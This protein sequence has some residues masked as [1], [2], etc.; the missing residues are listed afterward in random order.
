LDR[1]GNDR[2]RYQPRLDPRDR[3]HRHRLP[4]QRAGRG[5]GTGDRPSAGHARGHG[6]L[7]PPPAR[8]VRPVAPGAGGGRGH[9]RGRGAHAGLPAGVGARELFADVRQLDLPGPAFPAPADAGAGAP[10]PLPQPG[11]EHAQ[12]TGA[13]LGPAGPGRRTQGGRP[14]RPE[15]R[16]RLHRRTPPLP[17]AHGRTRR[18]LA[19]HPPALDLARASQVS[20]T[21]SGLRDTD[22]IPCSISHWARSGWSLGPCPQMPTYL[23]LARAVAMAMDSIFFTA[24]S[25]SSNSPATIA[26]S[27]SRPTVS[28]VM[29]LE[30]IEKPSKISRNSSA[31]RAFEGISHIMMI[32]S[33]P[34]PWTSPFSRS[35]STT[36]RPS[37][38]V[39]TNGIITQRLSRPISSRTRLTA[40]H[41]SAKQSLNDGS[42]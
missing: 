11:R 21:V 31:S 30:P 9:G 22:S 23:P 18:L 38:R 15:R 19:S 33:P 6:R 25:R 42:T 39:R 3:H 17:Q 37:S 16:P 26:E 1:P 8:Q 20:T 24:G 13:P 40:R 36:L 2:A 32:F 4:A 34:S 7:E 27:R 10:L 41:S 28:W 29:S 12:G 35:T 14:H 5:A